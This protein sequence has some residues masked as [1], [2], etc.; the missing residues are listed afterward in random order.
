MALP[1][2]QSLTS[3]L[4]NESV[5][6][7]PTTP[8]DGNV[9]RP[10]LIADLLKSMRDVNFNQLVEEYGSMAG[11][12]NTKATPMTNSLMSER[13]RVPQTPLQTQTANAPKAPAAIVDEIAQPIA[14]PTP[15]SNAMAQN[16]M[17][18]IGSIEEQQQGLM[19][20]AP[21]QI[22]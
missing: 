6:M 12:T 19:S 18:P 16:N 3:Q 5:R 17:S 1:T 13:E 10:M 8:M 15:M 11:I 22:A 21:Q 9:T 20:N 4:Q 2:T 14:V 7:Q